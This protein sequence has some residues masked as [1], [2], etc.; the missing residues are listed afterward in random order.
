MLLAGSFSKLLYPG[1]RIAY[2]VVPTHLVDAFGAALSLTSRYP[3]L[4][5]Q[6]VLATFIQEGHLARHVRRMRKV[7]LERAQLFV[8]I[9][10]RHWQ[11]LIAL[12]ELHAGLDVTAPLLQAQ[13]DVLV[14]QRLR[15][16]G[17]ESQPLRAYCA[18]ARLPPALV[19]GFA[20]AREDEMENAARVVG[21]VLRQ[22]AK[23]T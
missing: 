8:E 20:A 6:A 21:K 1:L 13:D 5:T 3:N 19:L 11:G 10:R 23:Q 7:Y 9:A 22:S 2:L 14:A 12:P 18:E 17:V 4:V 16:A 15:A